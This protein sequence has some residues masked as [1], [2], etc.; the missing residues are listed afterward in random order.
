MAL[1]PRALILSL[2]LA[3]PVLAQTAEYRLD[4]QGNWAAVRPAELSP[5]EQLMAEARQLLADNKPE[6]AKKLLDDWIEKNEHGQHPL[7]ARAY[8][9]RG[10]AISLGGNEYE[11]LY[12]YEALIINYP[13]SEEY[14]KAV[15]RELEIAIRY[16][17]GLKRKLWGVRWVDATDT[18]EELL[19]RVQERLPGDTLAERAAIELAD[20]YYNER[21]LRMASDAYEIFVTNFPRSEQAP[22]ARQRRI[23]S[24]MGRFKGPAYDATG[25]RDAKVLIE[26]YEQVDPVGARQAGLSDAM[27]ARLDESMAAQMLEKARWYIKRGDSVA[28]RLVLQRLV[29]RHAGTVAAQR[30]LE[31]LDENK[32]AVVAE[33]PAAVPEAPPAAG[34]AAPAAPESTGEGK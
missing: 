3:A 22:W 2:L 16:V 17:H 28:A 24:N 19:V 31:V 33:S 7:L 29:K 25:L 13:A 6:R 23:Y 20:Y 11:A 34:A 4:A 5:D 18:G 10:D 14:R 21:D 12:D 32:W 30:G 27:V 26:D 1:S 15:E 8:L 9:L